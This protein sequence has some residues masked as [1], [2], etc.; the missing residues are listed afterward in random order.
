MSRGEEEISYFTLPAPDILPVCKA[1]EG[2]DEV[3]APDDGNT[4]DGKQAACIDWIWTKTGSKLG[5]ADIGVVF[6]VFIV[7]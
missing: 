4:A 1:E 7:G 5:R 2:S 3:G 6:K